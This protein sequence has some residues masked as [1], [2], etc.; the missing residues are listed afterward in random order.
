MKQAI[1]NRFAIVKDIEKQDRLL[2]PTKPRFFMAPDEY[3]THHSGPKH[4]KP[5]AIASNLKDRY[6]ECNCEVCGWTPPMSVKQRFL[7][8]RGLM[9]AH[10]ILPRS[11]GGADIKENMIVIC[12]I[13]HALAHR[14]GRI[15]RVKKGGHKWSGFTT[16]AEMIAEIRDLLNTTT[17]ATTEASHLETASGGGQK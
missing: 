2:A 17:G 12:P 11:C 6:E 4:R 1:W 13:C 15:I 10:H 16:R 9:H 14:L 5:S 7:D 8:W 3:Q